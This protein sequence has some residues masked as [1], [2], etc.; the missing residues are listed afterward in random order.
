MAKIYFLLKGEKS[1]QARDYITDSKVQHKI[2]LSHFLVKTNL[3]LCNYK[4]VVK[5]TA[6]HFYASLSNN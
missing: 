6:R 3:E 2:I 5:I 4:K 1:I